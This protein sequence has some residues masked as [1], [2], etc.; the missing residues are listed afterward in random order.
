MMEK[1]LVK[2]EVKSELKGETSK[3]YRDKRC[4]QRH[5]V[6]W[7]PLGTPLISVLSQHR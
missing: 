5:P 6:D 2:H 3:K 7:E 1:E 4:P